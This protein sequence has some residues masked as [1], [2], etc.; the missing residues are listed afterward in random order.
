MN[1]GII[2]G[3]ITYLLWG[4][5][6]IYWKLLK[7]VP[8]DQILAHRVIWSFFLILL[9]IL[10]Q[11]RVKPFVKKATNPKVLGVFLIA[12]ALIGTNWMIYI[13]AVN[14]G[15]IVESSLGYFINPLIN[16]LFGV[17][18]LKETIRPFQWVPIGLATIGVIYLTVSYGSLP[19][20]ALALA[21]LFGFYGLVKKTTT[22]LP[23]EGL[24]LETGILFLPALIWLFLADHN[25]T[26]VFLHTNLQTN[27]LLAGAGIATVTPLL[28]FAA[29][30]KHIPLSVIGILQYIAPTLQFLIGVL[31]YDEPFTSTQL[32]GF[33]IIWVALIL[34]SSESWYHSR[35]S[36]ST[37]TA[38]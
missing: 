19:W 22:L 31:V 20:I 24:T 28:T 38:N 27:L 1:I 8:A 12:A 9:V 14:A 23:V 2:L 6:P 18:F 11:R 26:G 13:W 25:Q 16:V 4:I 29:A 5:L 3:I 30:L 34:F 10:F 36:H 35:K 33:S 32:V 37:V 15:F 7:H 21:F 17:I